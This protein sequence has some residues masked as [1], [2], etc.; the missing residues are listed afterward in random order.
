[1]CI[2]SKSD[3]YERLSPGARALLGLL[4]PATGAAAARRI[5]SLPSDVWDETLELA[6]RHGVAPLLY[7]ALQSGDALAELLDHI[8]SRLEQERRSTALDNLRKYGQFRGVARALRERDIPVIALKGLHLAEL[9]YR[10]ISLRPMSDLDIL[11]PRSQIEQAV[12]TLHGLDYGSAEDMSSAAGAM[13]DI[14][15]NIG[16]AQRDV[17]AWLELHWS[18][19]EPPARYAAAVDAVW[20]SA[21]PARLG[22]TDTLVMSSEFL[23]LHVCAHLACNHTF[24][25]GLRALCDIAE[26]VRQHPAIDW[27]VVVDH[28]RRHGW[29]RGIAAALRLASDHLGVA[30]PADAL[31]ALGADAL[32]PGMLAEAME[33]LV[34]GIDM[35]GELLHAPNLMTLAGKHGPAQKLAAL[36]TRIFVP[37]AELA[38]RYGVPEHSAR[39]NLY[40]AVRMRDLLRKYA[41]SAWALN[42]SDPQ[43]AAAAS[44][45]ARLAKWVN[46][47]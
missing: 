11:V 14:K 37:R 21:V 46:G 44:R 3:R 25:F 7:R 45:H 20:H 42:V 13:L 2:P 8:R 47:A 10:D 36:W 33:H 15:C 35:P 40:Y 19:D 26:I 34:T 18:L 1:M 30:M 17:D 27:T 31:A 23:L 22:D 12:A 4:Q 9:V 5:G 28:G 16:F 24:A 41:A 38:L 39:L 43:L 6:L 32:D 29:S